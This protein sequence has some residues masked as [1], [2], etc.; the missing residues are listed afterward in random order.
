MFFLEAL[1]KYREKN[2]K[3]PNTIVIYRGGVGDGQ[4]SYVHKVEVDAV[5]VG[6]CIYK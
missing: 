5:K 6:I 4:I 3:L 2:H 1:T